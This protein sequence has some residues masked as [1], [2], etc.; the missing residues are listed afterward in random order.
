M[1]DT[2]R[3]S[4]GADVQRLISIGLGLFAVGAGLTTLGALLGQSLVRYA[5]L[6]TMGTTFVPLPADTFT[7]AAASANPALT[8]ALVGGAV[9]AAVVL[10]ERRWVLIL[11]ERPAFDRVKE[12]FD[13]NRY[14]A[15]TDR[16]MFVTLLV[17]GF[18]FFEPFRL[19][20]VIRRYPAGK[21]ALATFLSRSIRYYALASLGAAMFELGWLKPLLVGSMAL[22][23]FGLWRSAMKFGRHRRLAGVVTDTAA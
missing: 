12:F 5:G 7:I 3:R 23:A 22:F 20:A 19:L 16:S 1:S 6:M 17:A 21:Y 11:I 18:L 10:V 15:W 13:T 14:M 4:W 9:N 2:G 8:V